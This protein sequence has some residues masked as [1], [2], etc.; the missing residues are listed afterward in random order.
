MKIVSWNVQGFKKPQVLQ[1]LLFLVC[2]HKPDIICILQTMVD[3]KHLMEII[4]KIDF[5]SFDYATSINHLGGIAILW[6]N[7][8]IHASV[9]QKEPWLSMY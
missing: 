6:N 4:L 5:D 9:L 2:T 7:G 1:E 3:E 8:K